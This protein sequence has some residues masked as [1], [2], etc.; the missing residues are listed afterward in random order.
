M[1]D[2]LVNFLNIFDVFVKN[3]ASNNC[4]RTAAVAQH[5]QRDDQRDDLDSSIFK[6]NI[7]KIPK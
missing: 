3:K 1:A 6:Q 4:R 2:L 5:D 7:I